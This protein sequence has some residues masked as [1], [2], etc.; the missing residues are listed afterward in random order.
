MTFYGAYEHSIDERGR[1]A[2]PARF[3]RALQDGAILRASPDG[4]IEL[5][6][7]DE[8][9]S[10]VDRRLGE[11]RSNR[12]VRGR[13]IRRSFLPGVFDVD[14][15]RQGRVLVP[16]PLREAAALSDRAVIIG[17]GDYV[18]IWSPER[19]AAEETAARREEPAAG[20]AS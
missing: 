7:P 13:R 16:Q 18:E 6:S 4:C 17:C 1:L 20:G 10:E 5:Y 15:D 2:V 8:F 12:E 11:E 19:W 9:Q 14:L 3:R